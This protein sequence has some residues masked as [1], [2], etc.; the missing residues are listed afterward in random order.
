VIAANVF[1]SKAPVQGSGT[2][3]LVVFLEAFEIATDLDV[4]KKVPFSP[5]VEQLYEAASA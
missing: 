1:R 4:N 3:W 5:A 2:D